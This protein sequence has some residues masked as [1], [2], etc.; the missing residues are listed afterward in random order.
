MYTHNFF[1]VI[2][3]F[4]E[5][6]IGTWTILVQCAWNEHRKLSSFWNVME[7]L[8]QC[9]LTGLKLRPNDWEKESEREHTGTQTHMSVCVY[10]CVCR[11]RMR[12]AYV[13]PTLLPFYYNNKMSK[14]MHTC[15]Y[16]RIRW[17]GSRLCM[18][19]TYVRT[20]TCIPVCMP[21]FFISFVSSAYV[22]V[23]ARLL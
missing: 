13:I 8:S 15:G 19:E 18:Y 20:Y 7:W 17:L 1:V 14:C 6:K 2:R 3:F 21:M 10:A 9:C 5:K 23:C 11:V 4:G 16:E 22:C 12:F